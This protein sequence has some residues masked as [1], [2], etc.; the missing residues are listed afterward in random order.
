MTCLVHAPVNLPILNLSSTKT[1]PSTIHN[2]YRK[3][4][5]FIYTH[6]HNHTHTRFISLLYND[7]FKLNCEIVKND[8]EMG[9]G[10][11]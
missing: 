1:I 2:N 9:G 8:D 4:S 7:G 10:I 11:S 3:F 6:I 5:T